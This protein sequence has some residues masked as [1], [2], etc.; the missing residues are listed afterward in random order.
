LEKARELFL[1]Y[2]KCNVH[3][4]IHSEPL[5]NIIQSSQICVDPNA[6]VC[7]YLTEIGM[8]F[9]GDVRRVLQNFCGMDKAKAK[10][11]IK[12]LPALIA[13]DIPLSEAEKLVNTMASKSSK[14]EIRLQ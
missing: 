5:D 10:E 2:S 12:K 14:A 7:V 6:R 3:V 4:C 9:G 13:A 1:V 11:T 8:L